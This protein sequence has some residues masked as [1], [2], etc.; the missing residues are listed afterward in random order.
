MSI[1]ATLQALTASFQDDGFGPSFEALTGELV[2]E[3]GPIG[4]V[5]GELLAITGEF[6]SPGNVD[7]SI[8]GTFRALAATLSS[9]SYLSG[10][11]ELASGSLTGTPGVIGSISGT[12]EPVSFAA[13]GSQPHV[14]TMSGLLQVLGGAL[15]GRIEAAGTLAGSFRAL[16]LSSTGVMGQVGSLAGQL[17]PI[18][19]ELTGGVQLTG[20]VAAALARMLGSFAGAQ[21][22]GAGL[23]SWAMNTR[24]NAVT[25]YPAYPANSYARYNGTYLAAGPSGLLI[26]DG[27]ANDT[28]WM[29]RTGQLDDKKAKLKRL[30]E[31]L[32]GARYDAPVRIKV[33]LDDDTYYEYMLPD[34]GRA[35]LQQVRAKIGKGMRSR[36]YKI[37]LSGE[38]GRFEID[39]L[40]ATMPETT[41][42]IG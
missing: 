27:D 14:G 2:G 26:L 16:S 37:E 28:P 4:S 33:W 5:D 21:A 3:H 6:S 31:L 17:Q 19:A 13:A 15:T 7:G 40:Q 36:Y 25:K 24:N 35:A 32:L 11:F 30:S 34:N 12:F 9:T 38:S 10:T 1:S 20:S 23:D 18:T 41:R 29:M 39:S 22:L 42:R 8:E